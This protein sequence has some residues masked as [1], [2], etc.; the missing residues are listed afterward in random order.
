MRELE[1]VI[2]DSI[3]ADLL[4]G[5]MYHHEQMFHVDWVTGRD[6]SKEGLVKAKAGL[7]TWCKNA[8][9]LLSVLDHQIASVRE[10]TLR[11]AEQ[12]AK[13]SHVQDQAFLAAKEAMQKRAS[14][15][16]K[17]YGGASYVNESDDSDDVG[18]G[19][20]L[21]G[22]GGMSAGRMYVNPWG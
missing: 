8:E 2:I 11:D 21:G 5:K 9:T 22:M 15:S 13:Y 6:V 18:I 19:G 14:R 17:G 3:Y 20:S 7:E 12:A 1:N 16:D 10:Q 4:I